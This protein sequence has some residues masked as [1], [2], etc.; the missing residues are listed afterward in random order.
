MNM[1]TRR[2][3]AQSGA[4]LTGT[5]SASKKACAPPSRIRLTLR[6]REHPGQTI[7]LPGLHR[8]DLHEHQHGAAARHGANVWIGKV[9]HGH[10]KTTT[11]VA[12]PGVTGLTAPCV[13]DGPMEGDIFRAYLEQLL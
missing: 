4:S 11:F 9:P 6:R 1:R 10:W 8:R 5:A 13:I 3:S 7:K 2:V 12:G